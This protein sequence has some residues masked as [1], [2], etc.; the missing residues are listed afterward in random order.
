[1]TIKHLE[2]VASR[3]VKARVRL[4]TRGNS[5][6]QGLTVVRPVLLVLSAVVEARLPVLKVLN[7][8]EPGL[9]VLKGVVHHVEP[10][11]PLVLHV[12]H[13]VRLLLRQRTCRLPPLPALLMRPDVLVQ[14]IR[15]GEPLAAL[16]THKPL[17]ARVRPQ[18][19]LQL[20]RPGERL[21]AEDPAAGE[22]PLARVPPQVRLQVA[23]LAVHLAAAGHVA[24]VLP[25][26][27]LAVT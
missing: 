24:N 22:G 17:L 16:G 9:P 27:N 25:L 21:G 13:L 4:I 19:P 2:I 20:I 15:P 11:L 6:S 18:M 12:H 23:C 26:A 14:V 3:V 8:V 1:M 5:S 7:H 10:G